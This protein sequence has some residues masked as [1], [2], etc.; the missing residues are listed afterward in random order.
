MPA[1]QAFPRD[2]IAPEQAQAILTID[3]AA[4]VDN[5]RAM[6]ARTAPAE[7]AA[8]VKADAYGIGL[9]PAA[10]ALAAAGCATFFVAHASEA[11]RARAALS[12]F[13]HARVYA[14]NGIAWGA[15][16]AAALL[17]CGAR[18]VIG[19]LA[20]WETWLRCAP[21]APAALHVDTGMNRLGMSLDEAAQVAADPNA[22]AVDLVMSH[23]ASSEV[24]DDPLNAAQIALFERARALFPRARASMSNSSGVFLSARPH[25]D[26]AR[27]GYALY[28]GNPTPAAPNPMRPVV[29]LQAPILQVRRVEAMASVGYNATW[30][31]PGPR[32]LA[33]IGVGYADG[34]PRAAS[35]VD[36]R[37][38]GEAM[39]A[40]VRCPFVGRVSMDLIVLDVTQAPQ[41]AAAP[42][43][44]VELLGHE[45]GV[46]D[47]AA[48]AGSIGYEILTALGRRYCRVYL[49]A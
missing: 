15:A 39:L 2:A 44:L 22:G 4:L 14:L 43:A 38:G 29:R 36:G 33:T 11:A 45:I 27:A 25:Y 48:R 20:E 24:A 18:P 40:G 6:A 41:D 35:G 34:I 13:A 21:G 49:G 47:L 1:P 3:L 12:A 32:T 19:S 5:W 17:A 23:F 30:H 26:L 37:P 31:A 28:G 46:D 42:G 8:V 7:C 10:Q 16:G 9:E